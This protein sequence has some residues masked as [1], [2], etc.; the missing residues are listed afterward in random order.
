MGGKT[1]TPASVFCISSNRG[2]MCDWHSLSLRNHRSIAAQRT[3]TYQ[4]KSQDVASCTEKQDKLVRP[5]YRSR[6]SRIEKCQPEPKPAPPLLSECAM[7]YVTR[8]WFRPDLLPFTVLPQTPHACSHESDRCHPREQVLGD[9]TKVVV[10]YISA[11]KMMVRRNTEWA[12]MVEGCMHVGWGAVRGVV[13]EIG[14]CKG[15]G[16]KT[17]RCFLRVRIRYSTGNLRPTCSWGSLSYDTSHQGAGRVWYR[18]TSRL[19]CA[20]RSLQAADGERRDRWWRRCTSKIVTP[21]TD[22]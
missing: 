19:L 3:H 13:Y 11:R 20:R 6:C 7:Q 16:R 4:N 9:L 10:V 5:L 12:K 1:G 17:P 8:A 2:E 15:R 22:Y 18:C 21:T 14:G